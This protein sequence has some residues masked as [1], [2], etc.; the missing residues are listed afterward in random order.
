MILNN[1]VTKRDIYL[2]RHFGVKMSP[3]PRPSIKSVASSCPASRILLVS[4]WIVKHLNL[5][6]TPSLALLFLFLISVQTLV[7]GQTVGSPKNSSVFNPLNES[8]STTSTT[9]T[10]DWDLN[11]DIYKASLWFWCYV[12]TAWQL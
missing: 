7:C 2:I 6:E 9:I 8:S 10:Q 12:F 5:S 11:S 1:A 3:V 4:F